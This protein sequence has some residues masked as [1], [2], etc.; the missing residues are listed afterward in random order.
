M[1]NPSAS[2][3]T[4]TPAW[5]LVVH[6]PPHSVVL[7]ACHAAPAGRPRRRARAATGAVSVARPVKTT[8][9]PASRAATIGSAP[10]TPTMWLH[11]AMVSWVSGPLGASGLIRPASRAW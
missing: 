9:A 5:G 7:A 8:S 1:V 4:R 10:S 6:I 2:M 11:E 3:P